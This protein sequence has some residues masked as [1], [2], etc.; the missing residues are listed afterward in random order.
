MKQKLKQ[1]KGI[2][3]V[4]LVVTIILIIILAGISINLLFGDSGII[5][6]AKEGQVVLDVATAQERLELVKTEIPT[7]I[8]DNKDGTVNLK[9]YLEELNKDKNKENCSVTSIEELNEINAEIIVS[10]K[11]KFLAHDTEKG[12]VE[13]TYLG[14]A[15]GL[16]IAPKEQTYTYPIS[17]TF[18]VT[19]NESE[20]KLTVKSENEEIA[21]V[22]IRGT[23]VTVEPQ[24]KAGTVNIVVTSAANGKYSEGRVT[25][26]AIVENGEIELDATAYTGNYDGTAHN[27][28]TSVD[29]NPSDAKI[30]YALGAGEYSTDIPQVT[31]AST[32]TVA[33]RASKAGYVTKEISKTVTVGKQTNTTG[34]LTL[35]ETSGTLTYP[36]T[37]TFTV[38]NNASNGELSV[39]SSNTAV[40]TASISGTT[41]K[42]TP[43]VLTTDGQ[44]TTITVTS[45]ATSNYEAQTAT[46]VATVNRGTIELDATAY[47]GNYD[48]QAH[49]AITSVDVNPSDAKIEYALG[50]GE[51]STDI[52]QVIGAST[53]TVAIRASKAGYVTKEINK[54]VTVGRVT[55]A[56]VTYE[57]KLYNEAEQI[58]VTGNNVTLTGT[59]KATNVGTYTAYATPNEN[60]A[61]SD[62]TTGT[63]T[64]TWTISQAVAK[65]GNT[66]YSTLQNAINAAPNSTATTITLIANTTE[67]G[68]SIASTKNINLNLNSKTITGNI[69]NAGTLTVGG[70][71]ITGN[72]P[73]QNSGTLVINSGTYT[74]T[75]GHCVYNNGTLTFKGGTIS[76]PSTGGQ[77]ALYNNSGILNMTGGTITSNSYGLVV[78]GG[79]GTV[80]GGT[81]ESKTANGWALLV[82]NTGTAVIKNTI[83]SGAP[84]AI[85]NAL[86]Y[87]N[88]MIY[89]RASNYGISGNIYGKVIATTNTSTGQAQE[90][91]T[92][93]STGY[94]QL[95]WPTWTA[96][97]GQDDITWDV[98]TS[99]SGTHTYTVRKSAHG[100]QTGTYYVHIYSYVNG[101]AST[102]ICGCGLQF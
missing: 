28:I 49:N 77:T 47:T 94:T 56:T 96:S 18:E 36:T 35:S 11:Y 31:G 38:T 63:K 73:L 6:R 7:K 39:S 33:I 45:A 19:S 59:I 20:G 15:G 44:T 84:Y 89:S 99:S 76:L 83:I 74:A 93:Y 2:T 75:S 78:H 68:I 61:W 34:N 90:N 53:Y 46:Y 22:S 25:H 72:W 40:A 29:V 27:A 51:Y 43:K 57:D 26:K 5:N 66:Y 64:L 54:T 1:N 14:E 17:G 88:C 24:N 55:T 95:S 69:N 21:K 102:Y 37:K 92:L 52:P 42:I 60:Y 12:N 30:E 70:G 50:V 87:G 101:A 23:T 58:G 98:T 4:S 85:Y 16:Q 32:Y 3:L 62:G 71:N 82:R 79:T 48:G 80:T 67:S 91:I 10:G 97:N 8:L 65:I 13:I 9:N 86:D 81:I 100:N 41:V